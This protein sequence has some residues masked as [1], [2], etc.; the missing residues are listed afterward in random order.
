MAVIR[1]MVCNAM[2]KPHEV[3]V[4]PRP[5]AAGHSKLRLAALPRPLGLALAGLA[6]LVLGNA[7][8]LLRRPPRYRLWLQP[9]RSVRR[10]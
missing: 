8:V 2:V 1:W 10:H 4:I 7:R 6:A 3:T 9:L 5:E